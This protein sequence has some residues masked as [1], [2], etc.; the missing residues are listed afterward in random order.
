MTKSTNNEIPESIKSYKIEKEAYKLSSMILYSAT[1]LDINEKVLI[2]IFPKERIKTVV[3]EVTFMNNQTYLMK[4]LNHKNILKLYEII[5]TKTYSFM[6]YEYFEGIKLSDFIS[7]KKKLSEEE[8][9]V[10]FKEILSALIYIHGMYLCDLNL[11]S[12]NII[13]DNKNNIKICDFKYGHFYSTKQKYKASLIGDHP[14]ACP[15]LHSKKPYNPE[16]AD[17]W[18]CGI[19]LYLMLTGN[20]PF[21]TKK[22]LDLIRLI[23][24]GDFSIPNYINA[25]LKIIIK[26]LIEKNEE[27][28]F[29]LNDL[30]NQQYFKDKKISKNSLG[31]GLNIL[32]IKYP[33]DELVLNI[34]KNNFGIDTPNLIKHLENNKFTPITSLFKQI[35]IKLSNKGIHTINDLISDKF[36]SYINDQNNYLKE[37]EQINNI[38]KY[39]KKEEE[40]KKNSQDVAAI[41]LNNQ[42][43]ISQGLED[44]KKQIE[45]LKK[46]VKTKKVQRSVDYGKRKR[47][48]FQYDN[49]KDIMKKMNKINNNQALNSGINNSTNKKKN[50]KI[51]AGKR[52]T[53]FMGD[54]KGFKISQ[55]KDS[56][57]KGKLPNFNNKSGLKFSNKDNKNKEQNKIIEEIK[58]EKVKEKE[59]E[60]ELNKSDSEKSIKSNESKNSQ[61]K[62]EKK[63]EDKKEEDKKEEEKNEEEKKEDKKEEEKKDDEK[64]EEEKKVEEKKDENDISTPEKEEIK[65]EENQP[66]KK[67]DNNNKKKVNS[68]IK[69]NSKGDNKLFNPILPVKLNKKPINQ[70]EQKPKKTILNNQQ[71]DINI[72]NKKLENNDKKV[73][74]NL[75]KEEIE[76]EINNMKAKNDL[77]KGGNNKSVFIIGKNENSNKKANEPKDQGF[78]N[79]KEMIELNLKKQRIMSG[80]NIVT[81]KNKT[82]K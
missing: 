47:G 32:T 29:K 41:L 52:N 16:L 45:N 56:L 36:K 39:L 30:F 42:N 66:H 13:I 62:E 14:F 27:K 76:R 51:K 75:K 6:I 69:K 38:Q 37:E 24:R 71:K 26:G 63:E 10:I 68:T 64:K 78:K 34:C 9:M 65:K 59:K 2:H 19:L 11:S 1:N 21:K 74:L 80:K 15:E 31:N 81:N 79:I 28:I 48:T 54:I 4:L 17:M 60:N 55:K 57:K 7:K 3:N 67:E 46:G 8:S 44:L 25:N 23:I 53:V 12:N 82:K 73:K 22:N 58:E 20:L 33:I 49:D 5:E 50:I 70:S 72:M 77:K 18:S 43:E 35:V 61:D 40:V